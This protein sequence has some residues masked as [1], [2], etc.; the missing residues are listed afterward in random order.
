MEGEAAS[1][2]QYKVKIAS[3]SPADEI[4]ALIVY[5]DKVA[6][7]HNTLRRGVNVSLVTFD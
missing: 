3:D 6:E 5:V 2:I 7:I 4:D 1:N